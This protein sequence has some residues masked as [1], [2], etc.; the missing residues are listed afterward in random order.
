M[1]SLASLTIPWYDDTINECSLHIKFCITSPLGFDRV[2]LGK[3]NPL[4]LM[5][6]LCCL[7]KLLHQINYF[8]ITNLAPVFLCYQ[9]IILKRK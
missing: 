2:N 4:I 7:I 3:I 5:L 9:T 1:S 6:F 8:L